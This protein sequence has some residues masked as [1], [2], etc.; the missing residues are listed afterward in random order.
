MVRR[1]GFRESAVAALVVMAGTAG[2]AFEG[3]PPF[4][5]VPAGSVVEP[6]TAVFHVSP[7]MGFGGGFLHGD[8]A[9]S[10]RVRSWAVTALGFRYGFWGPVEAFGFVPLV[11][12]ESPQRFVNVRTGG[13]P[14][15]Y[16]G[17]LSGFD[18]GDPG[19]GVRLRAFRAF[20]ERLEATL[21]V[22]LLWPLG[23]N[24]WQN[25]A[26]NYVTGPGNPDFASGDGAI[27][28]LLAVEGRWATESL[29]ASAMIGYLHRFAQAA[30]AMEP[31]ASTITV[32]LPAPVFGWL[33]G[34]MPV[35]DGG[36]WAGGRLDGFWAARGGIATTGLLARPPS[37]L[38]SILDSYLNLLS[39]SGGL[40][41]GPGVR[42]E[43]SG[44]SGLSIEVLAPLYARGLYRAWRVE[45]ALTFG[46]RPG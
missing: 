41:A 8:A 16:A 26:N 14:E 30:S 4:A 38:P 12:G 6:Y 5:A 23:T 21:S 36:W 39:P 9:S 34:E 10:L 32:T 15:I 13:A 27:K 2:F 17:R 43:L 24:V 3:V 19:G 25:S 37:A 7:G 46:W 44:T 45:A 40:W 22:G 1:L 31:P 20:E 28:L 35:G 33:R 18:G 11:W 29:K 42:R